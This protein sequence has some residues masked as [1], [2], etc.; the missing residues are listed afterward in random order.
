MNRVTLI[1]NGE[2]ARQECDES[3]YPLAIG[4][5]GSLLALPGQAGTLAHIGLDRG[6]AFI[7][8]AA[9]EIPVWHN[10]QR[11]AESAWLKSGDR[12]QIGD[13][14]IL[15]QVEGDRVIVSL[16]STE[17]NGV[18]P[19]TTPP[20]LSTQAP[21]VLSPV[22]AMPRRHILKWSL[23]TLFGVLVIL[24]AF[25]L[26]A[27]PVTLEIEPEPE[28]LVLEGPL[29][30]FE[31]AGRSLLL[32][33]S[34]SVTARQAGYREL[35]K[36]IDVSFGQPLSLAWSMEKLPGILTVLSVPAGAEV[37]VDDEP[38]GPTPL[39]NLE[40]PSGQYRL[41]LTADR[42]RPAELPLEVTGLGRHQQIELQLEADW[43]RVSLSSIPSDAQIMNQGESLGQ[44][45][46]TIELLSGEYQLE[47][48]KEGYKTAVIPLMVEAGKDLA[49]DP[50]TLSVADA[51]VNL[52]SRPSGGTVT[53]DGSFKGV[54]PL[55]LQVTSRAE[56]RIGVALAGYKSAQRKINLAP[57]ET[58]D[59]KVTLKPEYGVVFFSSQPA[60]ARLFVDGKPRGSAT[61]RLTLSAIPHRIEIRKSGYQTHK[62]T[63]TPSPGVS[64]T[65]EVVLQAKNGGQALSAPPAGRPRSAGI[66]KKVNA[67]GSFTMGAS[68]R[69]PGRRANENRRKVGLKRPFE[70]ATREVTNGDFRRFRGNHNSGSVQGSS[71]NGDDQPVVNISWDDAARYLNWLSQQDGLPVAYRESNGKMQLVRPVT[72]G[73][74]LPT[75]AEWAYVARFAGRS[76]K[77]RYPWAGDRFPPTGI[78]GN[79]A[80]SSARAILPVTLDDY[81]DGH[82]VSAQVGSFA[83]NPFGLYDMDGNVAE[84][85]QDYYSVY[86]GGGADETVDPLGPES[87][88]HHVVR[89]SGWRDASITELRLS[90]RDYSERPRDDLGFRVARYTR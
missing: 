21:P 14:I 41:R 19:P 58:L 33:G 6:H 20:P 30:G 38:A 53:L 4:G 18:T 26:L 72:T 35:R 43:A 46:A 12:V 84:W 44:T 15:W 74:R 86:P 88:R 48:V 81:R 55:K 67:P 90:Y 2:G 60:D 29:P 51:V 82:A 39:R 76:K 32:P 45:P 27:T 56:H 10:N 75:E 37:F 17:A 7:Q 63:V 1:K 50:V 59:L 22:P 13:S 73:Y 64:R 34:Y 16:S 24:A 69:E 65:L 28:S 78:Q 52:T 61:S 71:Q 80:D 5:E 57:A 79:Y 87:G 62:A 49:L 68:R 85:V 23:F 47:L 9:S 54:T 8:P 31:L 36:S 3:A 70:I 40:L 83:P 77:A 11:L 66:W 42:Y 25:V 89:G